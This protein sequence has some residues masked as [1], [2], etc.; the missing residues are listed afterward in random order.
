MAFGALAGVMVNDS[1]LR[2]ST[3]LKRTEEVALGDQDRLPGSQIN[4]EQRIREQAEDAG[5]L[6]RD[7][8]VEVSLDAMPAARTQ[9]P[10][11][12]TGEGLCTGL[13]RYGCFI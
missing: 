12:S 3:Y 2:V 11:V 10:F 13:S 4:L 5:Y 6:I 1:L 9:T 8:A 7:K